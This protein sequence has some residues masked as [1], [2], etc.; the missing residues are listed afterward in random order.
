MGAKTQ[1]I[2]PS[3]GSQTT[4]I[5]ALTDV[6]GRPFELILMPGDVSDVTVAL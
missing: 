1:A 4:K 5:D 2:G 6:V 3:R